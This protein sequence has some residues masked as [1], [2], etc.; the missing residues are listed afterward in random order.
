M[1][2]DNKEDEIDRKDLTDDNH[3]PRER[4]YTP[5]CKKCKYF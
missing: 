1:K 3:I 5:K 4:E 2:I